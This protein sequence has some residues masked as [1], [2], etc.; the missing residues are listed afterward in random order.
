MRTKHTQK[1]HIFQLHLTLLAELQ[2]LPAFI[3]WTKHGFWRVLYVPHVVQILY[4]RF[5]VVYGYVLRARG[6]KQTKNWAKDGEYM[7]KL[8]QSNPP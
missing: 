7:I 2:Q 3:N 6:P 5:D 4:A 8:R 1:A